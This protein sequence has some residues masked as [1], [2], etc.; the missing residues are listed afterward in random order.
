MR[1]NRH[2]GTDEK[3]GQCG[4][5]DRGGR[6]DEV[7][8][9]SRGS[10]LRAPESSVA[11]WVL[12]RQEGA[13]KPGAPGEIRASSQLPILRAPGQAVCAICVFQVC[14][15]ASSLILALMACM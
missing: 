12:H 5:V 4:D 7:K 10:L 13:G 8:K 9:G 2:W 11:R 6:W 15:Q 3:W 1:Q 14:L